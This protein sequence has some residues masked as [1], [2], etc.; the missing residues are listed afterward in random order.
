MSHN[1][2]DQLQAYCATQ[3]LLL[4]VRGLPPLQ[5]PHP[6]LRLLQPHYR[7]FGPQ[8]SKLPVCLAVVNYFHFSVIGNR[9]L[10][11]Y[12]NDGLIGF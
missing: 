3:T 1:S 7:L 6:Q 4:V 12:E 11:C 8:T 9:S 2:Q 10:T 5:E